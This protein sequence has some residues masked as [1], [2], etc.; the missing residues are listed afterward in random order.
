MKRKRVEAEA[1]HSQDMQVEDEEV[2]NDKVVLAGVDVPQK[3]KEVVSSLEPPVDVVAI[4][5]QALEERADALLDE[6]YLALMLIFESKMH[7]D[8]LVQAV[9]QAAK[10][11]INATRVE[12]F[13]RLTTFLIGNFTSAL[14][15]FLVG[16]KL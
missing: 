5:S 6:Y 12:C 11:V 1:G 9:M 14:E 4:R 2:P 15:M 3:M 8:A 16:N 7:E 13:K 10:R